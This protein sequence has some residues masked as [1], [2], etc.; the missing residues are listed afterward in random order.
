MIGR[1]DKLG[2]QP[3][4][5]EWPEETDKYFNHELEPD[6]PKY[7]YL[8]YR[9]VNQDS[10]YIGTRRGRANKRFQLH[11]NLAPLDQRYFD[12]NVLRL[13][14]GWRPNELSP[15]SVS[16]RLDELRQQKAHIP[17]FRDPTQLE[18][19]AMPEND[20]NYRAEPAFQMPTLGQRKFIPQ[21]IGSFDAAIHITKAVEIDDREE[22]KEIELPIDTQ[23]DVLQG[24]GYEFSID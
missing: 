3:R 1:D 7:Q 10:T 22:L 15:D 4:E 14:A 8:Y 11:G 20:P 6:H 5:Y 17:E 2:F 12:P 13:G 18:R 23:N 9:T 19:R 21:G 16:D 24:M